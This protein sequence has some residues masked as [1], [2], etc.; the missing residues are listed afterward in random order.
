MVDEWLV[1]G[2]AG[3]P[4]GTSAP[5]VL[6]GLADQAPQRSLARWPRHPPFW[7]LSAP[8]RWPRNPPVQASI[9]EKD[10]SSSVETPLKC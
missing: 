4:G 1:V 7:H 2:F 10:R 3:G 6:V 8:E 9:C 5:G